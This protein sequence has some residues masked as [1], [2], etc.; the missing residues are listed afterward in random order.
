[1]WSAYLNNVLALPIQSLLMFIYSRPP[2]SESPLEQ[3]I[4]FGP[5]ALDLLSQPLV[6]DYLRLKFGRTLPRW[7]DQ[8]PCERSINQ[9]FYSYTHKTKASTGQSDS[10]DMFQRLLL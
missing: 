1:M 7:D 4:R 8:K 5:R 3:A 6:M 9:A 2:C 10:N